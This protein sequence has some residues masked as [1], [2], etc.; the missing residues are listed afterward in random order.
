MCTVPSRR[1]LPAGYEHSSP[2]RSSFR[3]ISVSA[4]FLRPTY[5]AMR[6]RAAPQ[7]LGR[8]GTAGGPGCSASG[9]GSLT[10]RAAE[11]TNRL[12]L[13]RTMGRTGNGSDQGAREVLGGGYRS[14]GQVVEP[15]QDI[16]SSRYL[17]SITRN[18]GMKFSGGNAGGILIAAPDLDY[19]AISQRTAQ[20]PWCQGI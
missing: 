13:C 18:N 8:T 17:K 7:P 6:D 4:P 11:L 3:H 9:S 15:D 20:E 5:F 10:N 14:A 19:R 2:R 16:T 1:S 12:I